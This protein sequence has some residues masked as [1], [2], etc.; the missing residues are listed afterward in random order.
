MSRLIDADALIKELHH[1]IKDDVDLRKYYGY[2][3]IDDCIKSM[4]TECGVDAEP[5]KLCVTNKIVL[6]TFGT[7]P[8]DYASAIIRSFNGDTYK[9]IKLEEISKHLM[10]YVDAGRKAEKNE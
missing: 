10:A 4:S 5:L 8:I 1:L 7:E 2:M 6:E 3:G 9:P